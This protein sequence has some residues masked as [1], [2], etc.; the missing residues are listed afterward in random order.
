MEIDIACIFPIEVGAETLTEL[1]FDDYIIPLEISVNNWRCWQLGTGID[2][3]SIKEKAD[4]ERILKEIRKY[5]PKGSHR[6]GELRGTDTHDVYLKENTDFWHSRPPYNLSDSID[7]E[8]NA[9]S[10]FLTPDRKGIIFDHM[11]SLFK[12]L[13][14]EYRMI[15]GSFDR[16]GFSYIPRS[17]LMRSG[18]AAMLVDP[19]EIE[20][21]YEDPNWYWRTWDEIHDLD[22][23][24]K[25]CIR[26]KD[27]L[28]D[29][30]YRD[31]IT[32][33]AWEAAYH[34]KP[35]VFQIPGMPTKPHI[36]EYEQKNFIDV[37]PYMDEESYDEESQR[38]V[39]AAYPQKSTGRLPLKSLALLADNAYDKK[40]ADGRAVKEVQVIFNSEEAAVE[41]K[42]LL[43][44]AEV[45]VFYALEGEEPV[46]LT[47]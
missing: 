23:G 39:Y 16:G 6:F 20:G 15:E 11:M 43:L 26:T 7:L 34:A 38:I 1:V 9:G 36:R 12:K 41:S 32:E 3:G 21:Q 35:G 2:P 45:R 37:K 27:I 33:R 10:T 5:T 30:K 28:D 18:V 17:W 8:V 44:G 46:E 4:K 24:K 25:L 14:K 31:L 19:V 13:A 40:T 42:N 22:S 47:D 29:E